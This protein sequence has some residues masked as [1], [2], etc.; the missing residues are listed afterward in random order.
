MPVDCAQSNFSSF[1]FKLDLYSTKL[2]RHNMQNKFQNVGK[3]L[4]EVQFTCECNIQISIK[5][6][7]LDC[8]EEPV[9]SIMNF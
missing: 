1:V 2:N 3:H 6:T 4:C 9:E 8:N 7:T 5:T